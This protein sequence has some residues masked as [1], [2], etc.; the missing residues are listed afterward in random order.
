MY[1]VQGSKFRLRFGVSLIGFVRR[2]KI[3]CL[4]PA[5]R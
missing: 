5:Y 1:A 2:G 4:K 3:Q